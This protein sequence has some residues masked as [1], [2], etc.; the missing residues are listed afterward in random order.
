MNN[1]IKYKLAEIRI[2]QKNNKIKIGN[3]LLYK[4]KIMELHEIQEIVKQRLSEKRYN[5]S[6]CVM[7]RCEELANKFNINIEI[8]KKVGIAHDIAKE[9]SVE[10]K[11]EYVN[12]NNIKIDEIEKEN[13]G[14]LH[15]KIGAD[16]AIKE[17]G[18]TKEMGEAI[19]AHTT[20]FP[21]MSI[22]AKILFIAD[23]T[24]KERNFPDINLL[25]EILEKNI[26]EAVLYIIDK[27][28]QLQIEKKQSMHPNSIIA[29]NEIL[30]I[31]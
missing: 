4:E 20:G 21:D 19:K 12:K 24:S 9:L 18:F 28:I 25:N 31:I 29:R 2:R 5:H 7:E 27:K 15:A 14:L 22:L 16:I 30:K 8:A 1:V 6:V 13:T 10:E 11:L 17:L 3:K 23:R 26:D